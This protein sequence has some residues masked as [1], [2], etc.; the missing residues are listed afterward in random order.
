MVPSP[1]YSLPFAPFEPVVFVLFPAIAYQ[2]RESRPH[3]MK[4]QLVW[5]S[6]L[7]GFVAAVTVVAI[8]MALWALK[9]ESRPPLN[10]ADAVQV[11]TILAAVTLWGA[12]VGIVALVARAIGRRDALFGALALVGAWYIGRLELARFQHAA[13]TSSSIEGIVLAENGQGMRDVPVFIDG[14]R[15]QIE[16]VLTDSTGHFLVGL[17]P[18]EMQHGVYVVCPAGG[19]PMVGYADVNS[20]G[21]V[22]YHYTPMPPR[23]P[24]AMRASGWRGPIPRECPVAMDSAYTWKA[25]QWMHLDPHIGLPQE[26]NWTEGAGVVQAGKGL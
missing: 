17:Q 14:G 10:R 15:G 12:C 1:D 13:L 8:G 24:T 5:A 7:G 23:F 3:P 2:W 25:P 20:L 26:P 6:T 4:P 9:G 11:I 19:A 18:D 22:T 16:R 21:P